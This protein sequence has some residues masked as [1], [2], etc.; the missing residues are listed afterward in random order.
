MGRPQVVAGHVVAELCEET[1]ADPWEIRLA[2]NDIISQ[3]DF[4]QARAHHDLNDSTR[5]RLILGLKKWCETPGEW[6]AAW[7]ATQGSY[8]L[9]KWRAAFEALTGSPE[10][11]FA[12]MLSSRHECPDDDESQKAYFSVLISSAT[13]VEQLGQVTQE[14]W[15]KKRPD[16]KELK[17]AIYTKLNSLVKA[18]WSSTGTL[19][20]ASRIIDELH[21][22]F[23]ASEALVKCETAYP[24]KAQEFLDKTDVWTLVS[25]YHNLPL[26]PCADSSFRESCMLKMIDLVSSWDQGEATLAALH[27]TFDGYDGF[28]VVLEKLM[29][30]W[31]EVGGEVFPARLCQS[32]ED[33]NSLVR[34]ACLRVVAQKRIGASTSE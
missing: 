9:E 8:F 10:S 6:K 18:L 15:W 27:R 2:L 25:E 3:D 7:E 13:S 29:K 4:D 20:D 19:T 14:K 11:T 24:K 23:P 34:Q 22:Y 28:S 30:K 31:H 17:A 12:E 32:D 33:V 16:K 1:K 5:G 21:D 26:I